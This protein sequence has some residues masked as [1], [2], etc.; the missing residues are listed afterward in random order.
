MV[1]LGSDQ[2]HLLIDTIRLI[3]QLTGEQADLQ[4]SAAHKADVR[5]TWADISKAERLLGWKPQTSLEDGIGRLL[6]W[7]DENRAWANDIETGA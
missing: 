4:F 7:Y 3:E 1:N 6:E 5:A 2:P